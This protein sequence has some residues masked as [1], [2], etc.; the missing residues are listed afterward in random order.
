[1]EKSLNNLETIREYLLG[2]ISD[3][4]MLEGIEELLF[5]N[6]DFCN[7][8]ELVEDELIND[9]VYGKLVG[10]DLSDF[11]KTLRNNSERRL[12]TQVTQQLK[13]KTQ[14]QQTKQKSSFFESISAFFKQPI[15]A[16]SF[17]LLLIACLVGGIFLMRQNKSDELASIYQKERPNEARISDF[18][19]A[20]LNI[21]RGGNEENTNKNKLEE[22]KL[23]RLKAV[24]SNPNA[25]NYHSLGVFY[26]TQRNYKEAIENLEKAVKLDDKNSKYHNDL[27]TAYFEFGKLE[28][29]NKLLNIAKAN[30]S[31]SK[32]FEQN[33]NSLE[34]L[35][36]KSLALQELNLP[37]QAKESWELYLGKDASSKWADEA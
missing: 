3:E 24:N 23:E 31:F 34:A 11:E 5:T 22:I 29:E 26:L 1:M 14:T 37:R 30:E 32:A 21:T 12:K 19:Y 4:K 27:G 18:D 20:P 7:K 2:R 10:K 6:D 33:P 17:A 8:A 36:N 15:Y 16:G 9:F 25:K 35:F 28:K 13:V